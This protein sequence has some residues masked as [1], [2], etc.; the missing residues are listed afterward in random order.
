MTSQPAAGIAARLAA[1]EPTEARPLGGL[2]ERLTTE[3]RLRGARDGGRAI[4]PVA[5]AAVA[6]RGVALDSRGVR[7][8][9]LFVAGAGQHVD[10]HD[11]AGPAVD[12]GATALIVE[13]A[14]PEL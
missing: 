5:L 10:G 4:G 11:F 9:S 12:A 3:G 13:R 1:A 8:G 6:V 14:I 2:I 7:P